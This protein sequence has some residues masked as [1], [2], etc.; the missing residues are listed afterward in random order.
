[1]DEENSISLPD[2]SKY[3]HTRNFVLGRSETY[4][5]LIESL[6]LGGDFVT[7]G[8]PIE[9]GNVLDRANWL[10]LYQLKEYEDGRERGM[11]LEEALRQCDSVIYKS[12]D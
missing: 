5:S 6:S 12:R 4:M 9:N 8:P 7:I 3:F 1:M 10:G 2:Y 11:S